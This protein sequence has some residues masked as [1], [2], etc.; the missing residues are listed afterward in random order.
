MG[1]GYG[2]VQTDE[3]VLRDT[4]LEIF[5]RLRELE[6][7]D[8]TQIYDTVQQLKKLIEGALNP[9]SVT[10]P[11]DITSSAGNIVASTGLVRAPAVYSN[12]LTSSYRVMY[13]S[14]SEGPGNFGH[15]PSSRRFKSD[16]QSAEV[17]TEAA[18]AIR[19]VTFR[20]YD[21]IQRYGDAAAVE[22]GV[23]AEELH[24]L[25]LTWLVDYDED[26]LPFSVRK[27]QIIFAFIP[28][29]QDH[30]RRLR[31]LESA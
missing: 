13:V 29:I 6:A 24:D 3:T 14:S 10:T 11:G 12:I 17:D 2:V 7:L 9:T 23:I 8:G 30:E 4:I 28:L 1:N 18:L 26:G 16:I 31:A 5:R 27:D 20:Y 22:W 15:V 25:G 21:A 19:I